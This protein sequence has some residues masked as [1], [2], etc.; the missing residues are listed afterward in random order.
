MCLPRFGRVRLRAMVSGVSYV[1][2]RISYIWYLVSRI[3]Y[4]VSAKSG[5]T[6]LI[7]RFVHHLKCASPPLSHFALAMHYRAVKTLESLC[8]LWMA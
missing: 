3:W 4:L 1:V 6:V 5:T 2:C 7:L 8:G